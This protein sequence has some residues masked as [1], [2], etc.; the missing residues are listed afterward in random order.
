MLTI[1]RSL[2]HPPL[3]DNMFLEDWHRSYELTG[4]DSIQ[5]LGMEESQEKMSAEGGGEK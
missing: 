4:K 3:I 1:P 5:W 2:L